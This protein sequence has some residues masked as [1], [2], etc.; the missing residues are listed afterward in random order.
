MYLRDVCCGLMN[1][2]RH[3]VLR[4]LSSS[5]LCMTSS[6]YGSLKDTVTTLHQ[7]RITEH[8]LNSIFRGDI[9]YYSTAFIG[10]VRF[11]TT[12]Y[13][14]HNVTDDSSII[15]Y[16]WFKRKFWSNSSDLQSQWCEPNLLRRRD[17][18]NDWFR[19]YNTDWCLFLLYYSNGC[20]WRRTKQC[21][22]RWEWHYREVCFLSKRQ[23]HVH[24]LSISQSTWMFVKSWNYIF[25][26]SSKFNQF[27]W[28]ISILAPTLHLTKVW[29]CE[30][31]FC[32]AHDDWL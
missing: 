12:Q 22:R 31:S 28:F 4:E 20:I 8:F 24:F 10:Q 14:W 17:I 6:N 5:C 27:I 30:Y 21:L 3:H 26:M 29:Q 1:V 13:A 25:L 18:G 15:F 7:L 11:T 16:K 32:V 9:V 2:D 19:V 23:R